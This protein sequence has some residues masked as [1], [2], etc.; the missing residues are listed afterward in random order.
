MTPVGTIGI[1]RKLWGWE[2]NPIVG[3]RQALTSATGTKALTLTMDPKG[4]NRNRPTKH[5]S[6]GNK[7]SWTLGLREWE[8]DQVR[9]GP[10]LWFLGFLHRDLTGA[11]NFGRANGEGKQ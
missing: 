1:H 3:R 11:M 7:G 10:A 8:A 5:T 2:P 4:P 6:A 9:E